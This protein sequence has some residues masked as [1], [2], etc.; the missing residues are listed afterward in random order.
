MHQPTLFDGKA[1]KDQGMQQALEHADAVVDDWS[2]RALEMLVNYPEQ[3]FMAEDL[4][5][6]AYKQGLPHPPSER[7]WG[8][9]IGKA[10]N[11]GLIMHGG[12]ASVKNQKA[13]CTPASIWLRTNM[14]R[15]AG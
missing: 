10:R 1:L 7:A 9:I 13:H 11:K 5:E 14:M 15:K 6:W 4:R 12:F 3:S 2:E 8:G